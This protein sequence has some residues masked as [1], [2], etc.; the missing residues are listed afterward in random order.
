[1]GKS[2]KTATHPAKKAQDRNVAA[3]ALKWVGGITAV[4]SLIFGL[5][6][7][8][9]LISAHRER[10][11]Q[12]KELLQTSEIQERGRDYAAAWKSLEEAERVASGLREV[13]AA[14]ESLA[15]DWLENASVN[16]HEQKFSDIVDKVAPVLD[17]AVPTAQGVRKADLLAHL[18]WA[19]FLRSRDGTSG[20]APEDYYRQALAADP[21]NAYAH[22]MLGHWLLWNGGHL[23]E[24][25]QQFA[26]ALASGQRRNFVRQL[27]LAGIENVHSDAA[28]IELVKVLNAMRQNGEP[29]DSRTREAAWYLYK[30][31]L[32]PESAGRPQ[33]L[34][35]LAPAEH[36]ATFR[37]LFE[38]ADFSTSQTWLRDFYRGILEDEA[39][40]RGDAL[41]TLLSVRS[42]LPDV[43]VQR[44]RDEVNARIARLSKT[45]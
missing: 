23:P 8:V 4:L 39:G 11:R 17:R 35:A 6:Q 28:G 38:N 37:W 7:L 15:M 9:G 25:G 2:K 14:Q 44:T 36:L 43:V 30:S 40:Q 24:A 21:Q 13:R 34:A 22:A 12:V 32:D 41:R 3:T 42:E 18:G 33:F 26:Q 19:A 27:Q 29:V 20:T 1:M 16:P 5:Q 45:N 31:D 10:D